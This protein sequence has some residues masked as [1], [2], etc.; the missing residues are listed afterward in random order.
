LG[1]ILIDSGDITESE[2]Q[3]CVEEQCIEVLS[4]VI[5]A[6]SGNFVF[7]A[8]ARVSPRTEIVPLN[9]DRILLEAARRTDSLAALRGMLPDD[10]AP[11]MLN[12]DIENSA[13]ALND[14]EVSIA[15]ALYNRSANLREL[16]ASVPFDD[17]TLWQILIS[18]RAQGWVVDGERGFSSALAQMPTIHVAAD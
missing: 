17:A 12:I 5:S 15:S 9:S 4:R 11:L 16:S 7:H 13:D 10:G 3:Q 6:S 1:S 8:D 2:L 18:M 14:A